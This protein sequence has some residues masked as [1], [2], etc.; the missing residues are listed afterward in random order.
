MNKKLSNIFKGD[1]AIWMVFFFLCIIS[2]VEVFSASSELTYKGGNYMTPIIKHA[3]IL[4]IGFCG[5]LFTLNIDCKYFKI[6]TPFLIAFSAV[7]LILVFAIGQS[8]NGASRWIPVMGFQFQPS[9]VAKGTIVLVTAQIL[10]AMQ[11]DKGADR[12]AMKYIL[13]ITLPFIVVIGL[14]NLSTAALICAIVFGMMIVGRI[15]AKQIWK[16][17]TTVMLMG[18]LAFGTVMLFGEDTEDT[19]PEKNLTEQTLADGQTVSTVKPAGH[20]G[21]L[22]RLDTWK[23]RI[24]KFCTSKDIPPEEVDLDKDSQE[25]HAKIAI[26]TCNIIGKWPGNS[27]Q[28]DFLSQA[29]SDFIYAI[30]IEEMGIEGAF[31][32]AFLY[33]VLLFRT[34]RIANQCENSYPAFIAMGLA[35]LLVV[36]ALFN[37]CVAV[38]LVPVTG[39]PL[40]LVSKGGTSTIMSCIYIGIILS[41]SRTA[42]KKDSTTANQQ[43]AVAT[44]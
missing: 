1:K 3:G 43:R 41:V 6:L 17:V 27:V 5:M 29:F 2:I 20:K 30:I 37:M 39:Q 16:M 14:E 28:R 11:T 36:Q 15:P 19:P 4:V 25:A 38:G 10:S 42:K 8:T 18:V 23:A 26:A 31:V 44:A 24:N 21:A 12:N 32:V 34:G 35:M 13:M 33:I 22:H 40:P 7:C 9:E